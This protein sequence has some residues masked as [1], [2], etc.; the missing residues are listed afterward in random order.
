M[1]VLVNENMA[2]S[3]V[4]GLRRQGHDVLSAKESMRGMFDDEI[5]ERACQEGCLVL[6]Q[7][8]DF[9]DLAF[10]Y[11]LPAQCGIVLFRLDCPDP[12]VNIGRMLQAFASREDWVGHFSVVTDTRI[13]IRPL[14]GKTEPR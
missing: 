10:H 11:R 7:D 4:E 9:G 12:D 14:P 2:L 5:L 8:K 1:R 13:R 6:T 3:V